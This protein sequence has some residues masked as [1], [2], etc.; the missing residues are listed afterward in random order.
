MDVGA[1]PNLGAR[2][3]AYRRQADAAPAAPAKPPTAPNDPWQTQ[4]APRVVSRVV[5]DP[6]TQI[7]ITQPSDSYVGGIVAEQAPALALLR[8]I[9]YEDAQMR[10]ALIQGKDPNAALLAAVQKIDTPT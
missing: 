4:A 1:V 9:A 8:Q 5:I 6:Q 7:A 10:Q 3:D 2:A